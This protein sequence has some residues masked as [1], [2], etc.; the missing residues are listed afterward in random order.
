[1]RKGFSLIE[2]IIVIAIFAALF[3]ITLT[4]FSRFNNNQ[5]LNRSVSEVTSILNE[6]RALTLASKNNAVYG[7]HFLS[8]RVTLFTGQIFSPSDPDNEV[9]VISS[10]VSIS[11]IALSGGGDDI[12][13]QR[14]TGKTNQNGTITLSLISDSSKSKTITVEVS[15]IIEI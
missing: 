2:I 15:G 12:I 7:V 6:A 1:M 10:K 5:A 8:D 9:N 4:A 3:V 14:L 11:N 13:F